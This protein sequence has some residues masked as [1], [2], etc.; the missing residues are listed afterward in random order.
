MPPS[1]VPFWTDSASRMIVV[2]SK[3]AGLLI[4]YR[5]L[6]TVLEHASVGSP[7]MD[8]LILWEDWGPGSTLMLRVSSEWDAH[9]N[10]SYGS[11]FATIDPRTTDIIIFDLNP[12]AAR[13][14]QG[15]CACNDEQADLRDSDIA[16]GSDGS[17]VC[18][19]VYPGPDS[20]GG[21]AQA[22]PILAMDHAGVT[23]VVSISQSA[24]DGHHLSRSTVVHKRAHAM[25]ISWVHLSLHI[26][27]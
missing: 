4:P 12:W 5:T 23:K 21:F 25:S 9:N 19:A 27:I 3:G 18:R 17:G 20:Y 22:L 13:Y 10:Y 14:A 7:S 2:T 24:L 26:E 6:A 8:T 11:R 15:P 1:S 16:L